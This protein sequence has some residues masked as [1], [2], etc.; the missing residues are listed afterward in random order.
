MAYLHPFNPMY[1]LR[2]CPAFPE[3]RIPSLSLLCL[4]PH[5]KKYSSHYMPVYIL[6]QL[7]VSLHIVSKRVHAN[8][9]LNTNSRFALSDFYPKWP[10]EYQKTSHHHIKKTNSTVI[11]FIQ[12]TTFSPPFL[13][14][15]WQSSDITFSIGTVVEQLPSV[16]TSDTFSAYLESLPANLPVERDVIQSHSS[17]WKCF[18]I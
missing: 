17:R 8:I 13:P 12:I 14:K 1:I 10:L 7:H 6:A 4:T 5:A 3:I 9:Q 16:R 2:L 11:F 18:W 15:S